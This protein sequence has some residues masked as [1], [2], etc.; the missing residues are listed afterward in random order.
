MIIVKLYSAQSEE[1]LKTIKVPD[2]KKIIVGFS[3]VISNRPGSLDQFQLSVTNT[4]QFDILS[5]IWNDLKNIEATEINKIEVLKDD[6]L[7]KQYERE[8]DSISYNIGFNAEEGET[9]LIDFVLK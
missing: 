9:E 7:L 1:A 4:E 6:T 2:N 8:V 3:N 5:D